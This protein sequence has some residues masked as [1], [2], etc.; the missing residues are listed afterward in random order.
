MKW[1]KRA[2]FSNFTRSV[3]SFDKIFTIGLT[4]LSKFLIRLR[5]SPQCASDTLLNFLNFISAVILLFGLGLKFDG[6]GTKLIEF[7][8]E[9]LLY[10][11]CWF[12]I[13]DSQL[14]II[15]FW[16]D[17]FLLASSFRRLESILCSRVSYSAFFSDS[18]L[19]STDSSLGMINFWLRIADELRLEPPLWSFERVK[20]DASLN[21]TWDDFIETP[22][23]GVWLFD[24]PL[25]IATL[26]ELRLLLRLG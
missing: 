19:I 5:N 14:P 25:D 16:C 8:A 11:P 18:A 6:T 24:P 9:L 15:E 12:T 2:S 4:S 7:W 13:Y 26:N 17:Y 20:A 21:P 10:F 3:T 22:E 23:I 1:S